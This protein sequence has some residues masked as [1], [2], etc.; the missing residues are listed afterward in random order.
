MK[1]T[2]LRKNLITGS[3]SE[4]DKLPSISDLRAEYSVLSQEIHNCTQTKNSIRQQ[5]FDLQS[6]KRNVEII[7]GIDGER[8]SQRDN[9]KRLNSEI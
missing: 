1:Y 6:A 9:K 7:L 8:D 3:S 5:V 2:S 4:L